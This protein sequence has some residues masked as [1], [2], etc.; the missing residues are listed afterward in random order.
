M[1]F[2]PACPLR[3]LRVT[4]EAERA[5]NLLA[6]T[7][8]VAG[9]LSPLALPEPA[10][11]PSRRDGLWRATCLELFFAASGSPLYRELNLSPSGAWNLYR[12]DGYRRGG[13][14]EPLRDELPFAVRRDP[15]RL[16]VRVRLPLDGIAA[17]GERLELAPAAVLAAHDGT[18][19]HWA[20]THDGP[21][22][23]F[24]RRDGFLLRL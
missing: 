7:W 22:P 3:A 12:F 16:E 19:S 23:D 15:G 18:V 4:C 24:H 6:A 9:D 10:A 2:D 13:R 20:L 11:T 14:P 1:P 5:G 17:E 8:R 21:A